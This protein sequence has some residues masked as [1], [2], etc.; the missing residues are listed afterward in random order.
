MEEIPL[1]EWNRK[2]M[3]IAAVVDAIYSQPVTTAAGNK[4]KKLP[5]PK[6]TQ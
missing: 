5:F 3:F 1:G 6:E 4:T 2:Q